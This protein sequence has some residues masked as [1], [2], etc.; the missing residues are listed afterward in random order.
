MERAH[1]APAGHRA[2][3]ALLA[4]V[5][6]VTIVPTAAATHVAGLPHCDDIA[7]CI[8]QTIVGGIAYIF[9]QFFAGI[10]NIVKEVVSGFATY[11]VKPF[12]NIF[13]ALFNGFAQGLAPLGKETFS[14]AADSFKTAYGHLQ[15]SLTWFGPLAPLA[16][17]LVILGVI[18]LVVLFAGWLFD[19]AANLLPEKVERTLSDEAPN[20]TAAS[21]K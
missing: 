3:L 7:T 15:S 2:L 21:K 10:G 4:L 16:A 13:T 17:A 11:I 20:G 14:G 5:L 9:G 12:L 18:G 1:R 8:P 6:S 19:R